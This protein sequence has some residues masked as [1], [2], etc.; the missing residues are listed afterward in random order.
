MQYVLSKEEYHD[1]R[2]QGKDEIQ[3]LK[4]FA[5]KVSGYQCGGHNYCDDCPCSAADKCPTP[6]R[7][8]FS[9]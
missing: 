3:R 4:E 9:K 7:Q 8:N 5:L 2:N 6:H 1:L